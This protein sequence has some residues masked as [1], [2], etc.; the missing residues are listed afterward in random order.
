VLERGEIERI[1]A[2]EAEVRDD[3]NVD[4]YRIAL[5]FD[6]RSWAGVRQMI[7]ALNDATP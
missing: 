5:R 1:D 3:D 7:D 2:T 4:L 6:R